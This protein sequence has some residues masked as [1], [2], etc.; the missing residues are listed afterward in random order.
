MGTI[1]KQA[2][3]PSQHHRA[4]PGSR[5]YLRVNV[6]WPAY[7]DARVLATFSPG[8]CLYEQCLGFSITALRLVDVCQEVLGGEGVNVLGSKLFLSARKYMLVQHLRINIAPLRLVEVCQVIHCGECVNVLL[9]K[10]FLLAREDLL[11]Q[12]LSF[13]IAPLIPVDERQ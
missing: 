3:S 8:K 6:G 10:L 11:V 9:A 13:N 4:D 2:G 5:T 1:S 12:H 7:R